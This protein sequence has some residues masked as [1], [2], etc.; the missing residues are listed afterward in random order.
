MV[1]ARCVRLPL[2]SGSVNFQFSRL[3]QAHTQAL[4]FQYITGT[5]GYGP[6]HLNLFS[7]SYG[8]SAFFSFFIFSLGMISYSVPGT[9]RCTVP[10]GA[11]P[12]DP[13]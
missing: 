1:A 12:H 7:G 9:R 4:G 6:F 8:L 3:F 11:L 13:I 10:Q 5:S 2:A